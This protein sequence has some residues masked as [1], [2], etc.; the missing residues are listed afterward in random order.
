M[1]FPE[2]QLRRIQTT[3]Q[4]QYALVGVRRKA[5]PLPVQSRIEPTQQQASTTQQRNVPGAPGMAFPQGPKRTPTPPTP[6]QSPPQWNTPGKQRVLQQGQGIVQQTPPSSHPLEQRV[7]QGQACPQIVLSSQ[8]LKLPP[9]RPSLPGQQQQQQQQQQQLSGQRSAASEAQVQGN[10][11]ARPQTLSD[12]IQNQ[13]RMAALQRLTAERAALLQQRQQQQEKQRQNQQSQERSKPQRVPPTSQSVGL[14][15]QGGQQNVPSPLQLPQN[16]PTNQRPST[17]LRPIQPRTTPSIAPQSSHSFPQGASIGQSFPS[18]SA[19]GQTFP[20]RSPSVGPTQSPIT[21]RPFSAHSPIAQVPLVSPIQGMAQRSGSVPP[22]SPSF[23][24]AHM[25][26]PSVQGARPAIG[27][28]LPAPN[29]PPPRHTQPRQAPPFV[30]H[31]VTGQVPMPNQQTPQGSFPSRP[32]RVQVNYQQHG[33]GAK[34][35]V[36][37]SQGVSAQFQGFPQVQQVPIVQGQRVLPRLAPNPAQ[38]PRV[39]QQVPASVPTF[40]GQLNSFPGRGV[41]PGHRQGAA[42]GNPGHNL[43]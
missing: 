13:E 21:G 11:A 30:Q 28:S 9:R 32:Q 39:P 17:P 20:P 43:R 40:P 26:Q 29:L 42:K 1:A 7:P 36:L 22:S 34:T 6:S 4:M 16:I 12:K 10:E 35:S 27:Y 14:Q 2:A 24:P 3:S 31:T 15:R 19:V 23:Q 8:G 37:P 38:L 41:T 25:Q 5:K 18:Q 33:L